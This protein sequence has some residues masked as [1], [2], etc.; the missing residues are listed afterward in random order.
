MWDPALQDALYLH[1]PETIIRI[2]QITPKDKADSLYVKKEYEA[3]MNVLKSDASSYMDLKVQNGHLN[4]LLKTKQVES[5]KELMPAYLQGDPE[6]WTHWL[7][8]VMQCK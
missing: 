7:S 2:Q 4:H 1:S 3:A 8:R 6:R 5:M